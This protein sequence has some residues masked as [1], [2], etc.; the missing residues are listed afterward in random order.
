MD[1]TSIL[2]GLLLGAALA[3]PAGFLLAK[4]MLA[5]RHAGSDALLEQSRRQ[6]EESRATIERLR[7]EQAKAE[8]T[9]ADAVAR[10][11]ERETSTAALLAERDKSVEQLRAMQAQARE[12]LGEAFKSTGFEVLK[13]AG[14][15]LIAQA[16]RQFDDQ[17]KLTEQEIA[18]KQKQIDATFLPFREQLVKQETLLKELNE[19][20][21]GDAKAL[22]EQLKVIADLQGKASS[23]ADSLAGALRDNR[24]R[25]RWGE[26]S[27]RNVVEMAGL[28]AHVDFSEQISMEGE[29]GRLRPD[30]TVR[31]PGGR[32]IPIDAKVPMNAYF[33]S[34]DTTQ[35]DAER[36]RR[37][38]MHAQ[39]IRSHVRTLCSREYAKNLDSEVDITVMFMPVESALVA[40]LETN[41]DLYR[42][43]LDSGVVITTP[44][45][46]LALLRTCA[47]QWQQAALA[48]N[49]QRIGESATE[50]LVRIEKF[51]DHLQGVGKGLETAVK[52][53][54]QAV[55]SFNTRLLPGARNTAELAHKLDLVPTEAKAVE[56]TLRTDVAELPAGSGA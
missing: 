6:A 12:V 21:A 44:S 32:Q 27:L 5:S 9:A 49:A 23:A 50:L 26:I 55:A 4:S 41:G 16:R 22:G 46:L 8:R 34:L 25:G 19:K 40:A 14:E 42:E 54:N 20:R 13:S 35:T 18:E 1:A 7:S 29:D 11:A 2:V 52:G 10:M 53:F 31:L 36:A 24:Q 30:M 28:A 43:A 37:R 38:D 48:E 17:R 39:A 45:T 33:D 56:T 47:L 15:Q 3:A 51:S